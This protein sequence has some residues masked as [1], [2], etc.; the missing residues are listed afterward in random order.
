M[1]YLLHFI[2]DL[3]H[4]FRMSTFQNITAGCCSKLKDRNAGA[5]ARALRASAGWPR[6]RTV[7]V[8]GAPVAAGV[9]ALLW[10]VLARAGCAPAQIIDAMRDFACGMALLLSLLHPSTPASVTTSMATEL[11][12]LV[13]RDPAR[14]KAMA[15]LRH[16]CTAE[17]RA[18]ARL[19][20]TTS[21][22]LAL[23]KDRARRIAE[24]LLALLGAVTATSQPRLA[25]C[26]VAG[27]AAFS[28]A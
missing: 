22:I 13:G 14:L 7:L 18:L 15:R 19:T 6:V 27:S 16:S 8:I 17:G 12:R 1:K 9:G 21:R 2:G 4:N 25:A 10:I 3:K 20:L 5:V 23:A 28:A 11:C 26:L 24:R